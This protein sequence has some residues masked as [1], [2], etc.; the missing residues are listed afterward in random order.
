MRLPHAPNPRSNPSPLSAPLHTARC[1]APGPARAP[2]AAAPPAGCPAGCARSCSCSAGGN[3]RVKNEAHAPEA[4][5]IDWTARANCAAWMANPLEHQHIKAGAA[6]RTLP[7][8]L[9][10]RLPPTVEAETLELAMEVAPG[11]GGSRAGKLS[12]CNYAG[13]A[14]CQHTVQQRGCAISSCWCLEPDLPTLTCN[15]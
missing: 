15:P 13:W 12:R 7:G 6:V 10:R 14:A 11:R 4:N 9:V 3:W 1:V 5:H 8:F 2:P